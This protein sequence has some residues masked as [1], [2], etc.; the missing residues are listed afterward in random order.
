[1]ALLPA[2]P[3]VLLVGAVVGINGHFVSLPT[4]LSGLLAGRL[5]TEPLAFDTRIGQKKAP[6]MGTS[7]LAVHDFLLSEAINLSKRTQMGSTRNKT[8]VQ[9]EEIGRKRN[10]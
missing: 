8:E 2:A 1:M 3:T 7:N 6:A 9:A 5:G 10:L 4:S